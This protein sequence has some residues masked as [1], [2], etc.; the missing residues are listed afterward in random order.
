M[1]LEQWVG[2]GPIFLRR[3]L[4]RDRFRVEDQGL[5]FGHAK[6]EIPVRQQSVNIKYAFGAANLEVQGEV[7]V[8][9]I[10]VGEAAWRW[11]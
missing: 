2:L 7:K 11:N 9:D 6:F 1:R 8:G 3:S 5:Y 4:W 10:H